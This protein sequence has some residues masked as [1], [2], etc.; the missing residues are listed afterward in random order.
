MEQTVRL[1]AGFY[2]RVGV[3][4]VLLFLVD[5]NW[6]LHCIDESIHRGASTNLLFANE[7]LPCLIPSY[8][9]CSW[10]CW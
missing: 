7:V 2:R 9:V 10:R 8:S 1:E 3:F 5:A 6:L 4:L